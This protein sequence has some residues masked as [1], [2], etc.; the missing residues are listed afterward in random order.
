MASMLMVNCRKEFWSPT[1]FSTIERDPS[2]RPRHWLGTVVQHS[3]FLDELANQRLTLLV[4]GY[5]TR[6]STSSSLTGPSTA[7]CASS[8]FWA[9]TTRRTMRWSGSPGPV[10]PSALR[11]RSRATAPVRAAPRFARLLSDLRSAGATLDL[12]THS[13]G[14]HVVFESLREGPPQVVRNAWNFASA[15]DN[16]SI[17]FKERYF[18]ASQRCERFY[19]FHSKND[20]VLRAWYRI[21]DLFDFDTALGKSGPEDPADIMAQSPHVKVINCKDVVSSHGGYRSTG[22]VWA[23]ISNEW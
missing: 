22:Q 1:E 8:A 7:G 2:D 19:V 13:L 17:E 12:N 14:A 10:A 15:V 5:N 18:V 20:P 21:G 3:E 9:V 16:E 4:H 11:S 23:Y 6:S